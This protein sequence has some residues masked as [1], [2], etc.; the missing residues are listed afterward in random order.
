MR[1][2][3]SR[4]R[5][6]AEVLKA[7]PAPKVAIE[8]TFGWYWA[9]DALQAAGAEVHLAHPRGMA[10]MNDRRVKND[11]RDAREL[12]DLLRVNRFAEAYIAPPQ[13]RELRELVRWRQ[14]LVDHRRSV[15]ASL[16]AVL[17]KCGIVPELGDMFGPG[18]Q[19]SSTACS[20]RSRMRAG[21]I[22][23]AGN[24]R[25]STTRS[26]RWKSPPL[27]GS[28]TTRTSRHC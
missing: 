7:G 28:K 11:E 6:V 27:L 19:K 25:S 14:K 20:C 2:D 12:A 9:V 17:G 26:A 10:A 4:S 21:F 15:K 3:N 16:H 22:V 18:G 23:N 24:S 13:L 5:L 1:I 8:A